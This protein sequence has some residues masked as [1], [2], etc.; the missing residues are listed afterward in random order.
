MTPPDPASLELQ[1][2]AEICL[3]RGDLARA[4]AIYRSLIRAGYL[5]GSLLVN[6][7]VL[8]GLRDELQEMVELLKKA[9]EIEPRNVEALYNLGL[10]NAKLGDKKTAAETYRKAISYQPG[11]A[12]AHYNLGN[13]MQDEGDFAAAAACYEKAI[14]YRPS[15]AKSHFNLGLAYRKLGA[16][17]KAISSYKRAIEIRPDYPDA[18]YNLANIQLDSG[19]LDGA[20][21]SFQK[22]LQLNGD[23]QGVLANLGTAYLQLGKLEDAIA[24]FHQALSLH[25][26]DPI[27]HAGLGHVYQRQGEL[28][29]AIKAFQQALELRPDDPGSLTNLGSALQEKGLISDAIAAYEEALK[30]NPGHPDAHNNMGTALQKLGQVEEAIEAYREALAQQPNHGHALYNLGNA[31]QEQG[32][33]DSAIDA[34]RKA[35]ESNA[36]RSKVNRNLSM[37]LLLAGDYR[38]GWELYESRFDCSESEEILHAV[39]RC[40]RWDGSTLPAGAGLLLVSEQGLGDTF[41]FMRYALY[42]RHERE[43]SI[44]LCA[45]EKLH[46]LIK[47]SGIDNAPLTPSQTREVSEGYWIPLLS[48]PRHLGVSPES[49]LITAPYIHTSEPLRRKWQQLFRD[50]RRP[51]VA[52]NWQGNPEHEVT[53]SKGRS[54]PLETFKPIAERCQVTLLSVQKGAGSEQLETCSFKAQFSPLQSQVNAAWDFLET[55]AILANCE[56]VITSDTSIAHLAGGMG[57]PTWLLLKTVPEW[58]WGLES[59]VSFW[60]P[61]MRLFR[62]RHQGDWNE[63]MERVATALQEFCAHR[64]PK[65]DPPR[66]QPLEIQLP[67]SLAE[68]LDRLSILEI[69]SQQPADA[70]FGRTSDRWEQTYQHLQQIQQN[71]AITVDISTHEKLRQINTNLWQI[72]SQIRSKES[73]QEFDSEFIQLYRTMQQLNARKRSLKLE[74]NATYDC[75]PLEDLYPD[76]V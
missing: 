41:Q 13:L 29:Q 8:C 58:R 65:T 21:H 20:I 30:L 27:C 1:Q 51:I 73:R 22:A 25:P 40:R 71:L 44:S 24:T 9:I 72:N 62:Q 18:H 16:S 57:L 2:Q 15:D 36:K 3:Q 39:P 43:L 14:E 52:I 68:L 48:V 10:A 55:A 23:H 4:E 28:Q 37:T 59:E 12:I 53:H 46:G 56:L 47:S 33:L 11:Y 60:Y 35:I 38:Q 64:Q 5:S 50:H 75:D 7:A 66:R 70:V 67:I 54:L 76:M 61:S 49:P 6:L 26:D 42:L 74:I 32:N 69:R 45:P 63:V 19:D 34:Y 31:L 17:D